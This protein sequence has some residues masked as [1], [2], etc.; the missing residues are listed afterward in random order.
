MGKSKLTPEQQEKVRAGLRRGL[1]YGQLA[2]MFKVS[3]WA[4]QRIAKS[5]TVFNGRGL[6]GAEE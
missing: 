1:S 2:Y 3:R 4:I 5:A 6:R